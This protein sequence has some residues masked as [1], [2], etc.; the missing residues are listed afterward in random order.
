MEWPK[1][2][3]FINSYSCEMNIKTDAWYVFFRWCVDRGE[4]L[5]MVS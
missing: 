2:V 5:K 4:F 3:L 1:N